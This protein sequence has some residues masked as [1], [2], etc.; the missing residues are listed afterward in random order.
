MES[1]KDLIYEVTIRV[2][3]LLT[4]AAAAKQ[5][6]VSVLH[7]YKVARVVP[8]VDES[9][10]AESKN[11]NANIDIQLQL[12]KEKELRLKTQEDLFNMKQDYLTLK[13]DFLHNKASQDVHRPL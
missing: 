13:Q 11:N 2:E 4:E 3:G 6:N 8:L 12:L 5:A 10:T 7:E 9:F 1:V